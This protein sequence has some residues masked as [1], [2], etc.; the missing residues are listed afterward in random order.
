MYKFMAFLSPTER[1]FLSA[2]SQLAYCNPFLPERPE[3]E[4]AALGDDYVEGEPVWSQPTQDPER[5]RANVWRI[6]ERLEVLLE[7]LR[8]RLLSGKDAREQDLVLYED[9]VIHL[10]YNRYYPK[11]FE[12]SFGRESTKDRGTR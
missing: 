9:G 11:F 3:F 12:S 1:R 2:V 7:P 6:A 8:T 4:R 5:P 10:L